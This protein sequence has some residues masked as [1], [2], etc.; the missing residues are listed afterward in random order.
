MLILL[1]ENVEQNMYFNLNLD[2]SIR[3]SI[4]SYAL[5]D[6]VIAL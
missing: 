4:V 2:S 6:T 3:K 5:T 1:L